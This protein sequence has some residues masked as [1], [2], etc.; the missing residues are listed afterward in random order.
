MQRSPTSDLTL[1]DVDLR[2]LRL[3][4]TVVRSGGI[5]AAEPELNIERSTIS[6]HL[7]A[8]EERLGVTLCHRGRSGFSLT[9]EGTRVFE[10]T[11]RL[12]SAVT[13]F[14]TEVN[15]I[16]DHL[17]GRL[18]VALFD[19]TV[20]NPA[21]R[22]PTAL[23]DFTSRAPEVGIELHVEPMH[24][25]ESG[26]IDGRRQIGIIPTYR[27]SPALNYM[28]LFGEQVYL[29]CGYRHPLF[30]Q[31]DTP[32]NEK[33]VWSQRYAGLGFNSPNMKTGNAFGLTRA[34]EAFDQEAVATLVLSGCFIGFL[35]EHYADGFQSK[36]LLRPLY[37][38]RFQYTCQFAAIYRH[39]PPPPRLVEII[40]EC[41]RR[42]HAKAAT[43]KGGD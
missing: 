30:K 33:N 41:L 23:D 14:G 26:V 7:K 6:R 42:A 10:S 3:F 28:P 32:G 35:P 39:S 24:E 4:Q 43:P 1:S 36:G 15:E 2:Q 19:K 37:P 31:P 22:I 27:P 17:R 13:T 12:L 34:A 20:T 29:Y 18:R 25:I 9:D 11:K 5:T 16:N 8:L 38:E 21:A 40:L